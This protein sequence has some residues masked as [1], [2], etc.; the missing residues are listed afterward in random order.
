[1]VHKEEST[2]NLN[3]MTHLGMGSYARMWTSL[4]NLY[5]L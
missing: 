4:K 2:K 5:S 1:M 3:F